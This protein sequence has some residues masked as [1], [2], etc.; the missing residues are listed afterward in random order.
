M[1]HILLSFTL[2]VLGSAVYLV[3][4]G[5]W[6]RNE[7]MWELT[8]ST[9]IPQKTPEAPDVPERPAP[10]QF[11]SSPGIRPLRRLQRTGRCFW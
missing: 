4:A 6:D 11:R 3:R 1:I 5:A 2:V 9:K 8:E 10:R 7:P